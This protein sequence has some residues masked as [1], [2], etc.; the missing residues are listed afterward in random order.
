MK[1]FK[2]QAVPV[3]DVQINV[4]DID[5]PKNCPSMRIGQQSTA[6]RNQL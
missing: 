4:A 1:E 3:G 5:S 2:E 6:S